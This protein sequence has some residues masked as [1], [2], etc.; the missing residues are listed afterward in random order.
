MNII[1]ILGDLEFI[2]PVIYSVKGIRRRGR[3]GSFGVTLTS[4]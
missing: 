1:K 3:D 4:E 2:R